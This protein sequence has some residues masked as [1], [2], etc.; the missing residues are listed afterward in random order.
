MCLF[1]YFTCSG[2]TVNENGTNAMDF[3]IAGNPC[4]LNKL[5]DFEE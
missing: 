5:T 1:I 3:E 4:N 2:N